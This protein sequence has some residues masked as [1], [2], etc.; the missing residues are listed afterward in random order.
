VAITQ[1]LKGLGKASDLRPLMPQN[2]ARG[3]A[4]LLSSQFVLVPRRPALLDVLPMKHPRINRSFTEY[5]WS[6]LHEIISQLETRPWR[7]LIALLRLNFRRE[8]PN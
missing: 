7:W 4:R 3:R 8:L 1:P 6:A 5:G 2:R